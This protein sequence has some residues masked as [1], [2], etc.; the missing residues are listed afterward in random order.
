MKKREKLDII[1][2]YY[3]NA[4][5]TI[6]S[7]N[8]LID[9]VEN[10]LDLETN[11]VMIADSIC[12][13]DVNSIQYPA[14]AHEFLGP[15]KMG[16]LDGFPFTG[17]TGMAAFA[18]HVPD[19]GAVF[20]YYGPHVG[21]SKNGALGEIHRY[22]QQVNTG[23]CGAAKGALNKLLNH[24]IIEGNITEMDYQMNTIEQILFRQKDR[25][26]NAKNQL[27]EATEVIYEAIDERI[28][29][30]VEKTSYKCSYVILIGAILINSDSDMGSFT[31][32]K[33]F[34]TIDLKTNIRT[35]LLADYP[36]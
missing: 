26:L 8:R 19:E 17:L 4:I 13:D 6:D 1:R 33:R 28:N 10:H 16:G 34:D 3:P 18:S 21:I 31:S 9:Y 2:Q 11:K 36:L 22:A 12:S 25:I 27:F 7:V 24:A 23:C 14:R 35:S 32:T 15:F 30:L 20:I 29:Q 5:T